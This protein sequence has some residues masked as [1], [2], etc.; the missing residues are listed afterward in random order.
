MAEKCTVVGSST[1]ESMGDLGWT[2]P[3]GGAQGTER[4]RTSERASALMSRARGSMRE[5]VSARMS[6]APTSRPHRTARGREKR[7]RARD[8]TDKRGLPV[9]EGRSRGRSRGLDGLSWA[10][11]VE[12]AF[13]FFLEFLIAFL[14]IFSRVSKS[15]SNEMQ[16]QTISNMCIKQKNKLGS[17]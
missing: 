2:V 9:R 3:M 14:F 13:S 8:D 5:G 7:E 10:G 16:I 6:L 15:N 12:L 1:T 11:W 17:A 4:E